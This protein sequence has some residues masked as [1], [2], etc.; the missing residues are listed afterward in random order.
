MCI[1]KEEV[2]LFRPKINESP[3]RT[4]DRPPAQKAYVG[5]LTLNQ[6]RDRLKVADKA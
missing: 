6:A 5:V 1:A 4:P 3:L 2:S